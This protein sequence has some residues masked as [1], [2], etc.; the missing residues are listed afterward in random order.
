M[1]FRCK[2]HSCSVREF[3]LGSLEALVDDEGREVVQVD[4]GDG[5]RTVV[6]VFAQGMRTLLA[7]HSYPHISGA[8]K[9][10]SLQIPSCPAPIPLL[11]ATH[12]FMAWGLRQGCRSEARSLTVPC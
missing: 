6:Q 3:L 4:V 5:E 2:G 9:Y 8:L 11:A 7:D 1:A 12:R 10:R